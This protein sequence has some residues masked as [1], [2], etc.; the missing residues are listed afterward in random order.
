MTIVAI[1]G[2]GGVGR[3]LA[4]RLLNAGA[5]V[6]FGVRDPAAAVGDLTGAVAGVPVLLPTAAVSGAQVVLLAVPATAAVEAARAAGDLAGKILVDSTNPLRWDKGP[7]WAP[8]PEGSVAQ[9]LAAAFPGI[10]VI[11]G[12][13]HFGLEIQGNPDLAHGPADALFAG[14]DADAKAAVMA[15]ATGMGFRARDAGPLRNAA[16]LENLAVLWIHLATAGGLGREF[17]FRIEGRAG[18][19]GKENR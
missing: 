12:F 2:A 13:N 10:P 16:V 11:K 17:G 6:R 7:V 8:P 1:L 5:E 3:A 14:D 9:A 15:L 4:G 19:L 18:F